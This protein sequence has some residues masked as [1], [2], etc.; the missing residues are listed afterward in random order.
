MKYVCPFF[1]L[2][3]KALQGYKLDL[4]PNPGNHGDG[5]IL[6]STL[7]QLRRCKIDYLTLS[8]SPDLASRDNKFLIVYGGGGNLNSRYRDATNFISSIKDLELP[9]VVFLILFLV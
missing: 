1:Y 2:S 3:C 6:A 4:V 7:Q 9:L 5:L 8:S